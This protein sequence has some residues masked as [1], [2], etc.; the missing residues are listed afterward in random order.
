MPELEVSLLLNEV[1]EKLEA[2]DE[3]LD[4]VIGML[5]SVLATVDSIP[6]NKIETTA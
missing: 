3:K 2:Q 1:K 5:E 6:T 4:K